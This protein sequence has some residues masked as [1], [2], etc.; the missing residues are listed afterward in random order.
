MPKP[1]SAIRREQRGEAEH[2]K[3]E[4]SGYA[5]VVRSAAEA[6]KF[7]MGKVKRNTA[8]DYCYKKRMK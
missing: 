4:R 8:K 3:G 5:I 6:A 1:R 7:R 2:P